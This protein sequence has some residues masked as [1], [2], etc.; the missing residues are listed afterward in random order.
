MQ[1]FFGLG[2]TITKVV[3]ILNQRTKHLETDMIDIDWLCK[4]WQESGSQASKGNTL[5]CLVCFS[6]EALAG[7]YGG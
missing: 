6:N 1:V 5:N 3:K 7:D 2:A 4:A